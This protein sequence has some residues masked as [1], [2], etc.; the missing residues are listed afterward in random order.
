MREWPLPNRKTSPP[1]PIE[2]AQISAA[3]SMAGNSVSRRRRSKSKVV[4]KYVVAAFKMALRRLHY[5]SVVERSFHGSGTRWLVPGFGP[6][7]C[8]ARANPASLAGCYNHR[9]A[10]HESFDADP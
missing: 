9:E 1:R 3:C 2:F 6:P 8:E 10:N 7:C 4:S 5:S